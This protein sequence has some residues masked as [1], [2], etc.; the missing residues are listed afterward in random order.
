MKKS[1]IGICMALSIMASFAQE[2]QAPDGGN[3]TPPPKS[4]AEKASWP[5]WLA[6]NSQKDIDVIGL[7][8]TIPYGS[9]E[10]VTGFDIGFF[11]R[12]RTP[13]EIVSRSPSYP[14][15]RY[16]EG[17]QL[18]ILRNDVSDIMAGVQVGIYNSS[19]R[20]DLMGVQVGLWNEAHSIR[21]VQVGL[22]NVADSVTGIQVGII[23]RSEALYGFQGG[24]VNVIRESEM[25]FCPILNIGFDTFTEP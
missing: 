9:C 24:I 21:G 23:N 8:L 4:Q 7:R 17:F 12:A 16:F 1:V 14:I 18:N 19:G 5:V 22:I 13:G 15:G 20:A 25:P 10:S 11:G 6:L 3:T 2:Q